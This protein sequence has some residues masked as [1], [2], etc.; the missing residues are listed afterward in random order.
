MT[1]KI[2]RQI[3]ATKQAKNLAA[4]KRARR[5]A[6]QISATKQAKNAARA[7]AA[8]RKAALLRRAWRNGCYA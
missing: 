4:A 7:K 8:A 3:S 6:R 5:I 1:N 2:A